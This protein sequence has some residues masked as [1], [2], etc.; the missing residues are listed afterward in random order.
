MACKDWSD[1]A[2]TVTPPAAVHSHHNRGT[3]R[4]LSLVFQDEGLHYYTR[5]PGFSFA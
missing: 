4:M 2:A 3:G 5:T 1:F